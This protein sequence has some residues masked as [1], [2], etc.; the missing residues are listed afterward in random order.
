MLHRYHRWRWLSRRSKRVFGVGVA[1]AEFYDDSDAAA[2]DL[3]DFDP[4]EHNPDKQAKDAAGGGDGAA[5]E[6]E[7]TEEEAEEEGGGSRK[8]GKKKS[9][10]AKVRSPISLREPRPMAL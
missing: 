8:A 4:E 3:K 10:K 9:R 5:A 6:E 7:E 1:G 2:A